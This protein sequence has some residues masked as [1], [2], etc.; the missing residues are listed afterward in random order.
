MNG[1]FLDTSIIIDYLRGG[2]KTVNLVDSLE[3]D[4]TSSY[5]CLAEL[6]EGVDRAKDKERAKKIVVQFFAGLKFI[7]GINQAIAEKF[8]QLRKELKN[9]GSIIEDIDIF[10]AATCLVNDL[11]LITLNKK[12]FSRIKELKNY[13]I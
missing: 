13:P 7:L 12:H 9:K 8:G 3:G 11:T 4:L 10:I 6:F 2:E 1:Y 5:F